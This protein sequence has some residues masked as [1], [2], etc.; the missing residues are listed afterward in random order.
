VLLGEQVTLRKIV[1]GAI[2]IFGVM[3]SVRKSK[4]ETAVEIVDEVAQQADAQ[5]APETVSQK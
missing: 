1:G 3:L 4:T 5:S 2:V